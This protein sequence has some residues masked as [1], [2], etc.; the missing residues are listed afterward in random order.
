MRRA[1]RESDDLW[2]TLDAISNRLSKREGRDG[3]AT[4]QANSVDKVKAEQAIKGL[5]E[6][7]QRGASQSQ[8]FANLSAD[9]PGRMLELVHKVFQA[10]DGKKAG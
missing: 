6:Q 3:R 2:E 1:R 10:K 4:A 5:F 7:A 8:D 9:N